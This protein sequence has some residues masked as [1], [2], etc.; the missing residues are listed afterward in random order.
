[1]AKLIERLFPFEALR[2][3]LIRFPLSVLMAICLFGIGI[4]SVHDWKI[5]D[6]DV[7]GKLALIYSFGF[8]W[9]GIAVIAAER[10]GKGVLVQNLF[11]M[12][13]IAL[14]A[15]LTFMSSFWWINGVF[16]LVALHFLVM[17]APYL[18]R[19]D[20]WSFWSYNR[21][22]WLGVFVSYAAILLCAG[23]L[24]VA[25]YAI[26]TLFN[27]D[28][29]HRVF[30]DIWLFSCLILG[31][32][33]ALSWVPKTYDYA[34]E[35]ECSM[36]A[37]IG[38]IANWISVPMG[39]IY[40]AILYTYFGKILYDGALPN[41][42]LSYLIAGFAGA[43]T[44]TYLIAWP[45]RNTG[46]PQL[47]LFYK[48]F[49]AAL[50]IPACFHTYSIFER[51]NAYGVT[52]QRYVLV[53][54]AIWFFVVILGR[55]SGKM[56]LRAIPLVA[57]LLLLIGAYGPWSGVSISTQSQ[58][59]RLEALMIKNNM[60]KDG[61]AVKAENYPSLE[62]RKSLSSI[63]D[64]MCQSDRD[65][66]IEPMFKPADYKD[67]WSCYGAYNL[68][69]TLGFE[70]VYPY[71]SGMQS[72]N[73]YLNSDEYNKMLNVRGY[74]YYLNS[75]S[76]YY[77]ENCANKGKTEPDMCENR[78]G[79]TD[80]PDFIVL[81]NEEGKIIVK[82]KD[83]IVFETNLADY[84]KKWRTDK[85]EGMNI[86][87]ENQDYKSRMIFSNISGKMEN[88]KFIYSYSN[89]DLLFLEKNTQ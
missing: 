72:D 12:I 81:S 75:S 68:T 63:L 88:E 59:A 46:A 40:L 86:D 10:E 69:E 17:V 79:K 55:V 32:I 34:S 73:V 35:S 50:F 22:L 76:I 41:G 74:D 87:F 38:F 51:I 4:C 30:S 28:V 83:R 18:R 67:K 84:V 64:Y 8:L 53:L 49:F 89:F 11:G 52:E 77:S 26:E 25:L 15:L 43:G 45:M 70:Y 27:V 33:Y 2:E 9:A 44:L 57:A 19:G 48:I 36:P 14:F 85:V 39:F 3:T 20:D 47:R 13:G 37:G 60:I 23:G 42:K 61:K 82:R 31:P 5:M 29:G 6:D 7:A 54:V 56:P 80:D 24:S 66:L 78:I 16:V 65:R 21:T 1:M 62:D 71:Y 58:Y